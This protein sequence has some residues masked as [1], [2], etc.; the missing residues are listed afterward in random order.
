MEAM[1][2]ASVLGTDTALHKK[3]TYKAKKE[4]KYEYENHL[5]TTAPSMGD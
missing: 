3:L 4:R 2:G 1:R 5:D